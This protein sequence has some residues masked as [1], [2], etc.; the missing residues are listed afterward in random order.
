MA[1]T[2]PISEETACDLGKLQGYLEKEMKYPFSFTQKQAT[3]VAIKE[4]LYKR[5]KK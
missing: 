5:E 4:A 1:K 2:V 3:A